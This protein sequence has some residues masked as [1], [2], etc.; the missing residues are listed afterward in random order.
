MA[1]TVL[2]AFTGVNATD[3][4]FVVAPGAQVGDVIKFA[5]IIASSNPIIGGD[6]TAYYEGVVPINQKIVQ[7]AVTVV[8]STFSPEDSV[9]LALVERP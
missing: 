5:V 7:R 3:N 4:E 1:E 2:Y 9:V 6:A 8:G